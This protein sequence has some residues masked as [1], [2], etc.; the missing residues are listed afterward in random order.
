L[1]QQAL[2]GL[3]VLDLAVMC[4]LAAMNASWLS[5]I[6]MSN[7]KKMMAK[8]AHRGLAQPTA[9]RGLDL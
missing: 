6:I 3:T 1:W 9:V 8:A 5:G 2:G 4:F 7:T